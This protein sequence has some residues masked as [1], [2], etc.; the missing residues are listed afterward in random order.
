MSIKVKAYDLSEGR[1][2]DVSLDAFAPWQQT[3]FVQGPS[4]FRP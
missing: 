2:A 1:E 4:V 3:L